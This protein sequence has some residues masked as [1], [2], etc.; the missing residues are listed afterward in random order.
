MPTISCKNTKSFH[1]CNKIPE[2]YKV[3]YWNSKW[4]IAIVGDNLVYEAV[5]SNIIFCPYC[6]EELVYD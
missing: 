3:L 5:L 6:G 1:N 2:Q 4:G